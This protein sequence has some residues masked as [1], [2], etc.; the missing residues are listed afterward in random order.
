MAALTRKGA[1]VGAS[2]SGGRRAPRMA[3]MRRVLSLGAGVQSSVVLLMSARGELPSLDL[4]IFADTGWEPRAVYQHLDWLEAEAAEAPYPV[5]IERTSLRGQ[6]LRDD[7]I[8]NRNA[9]GVDGFP[10]IPLYTTDP[11]NGR[12][13]MVRRQCTQDYKIEPIKRAI[14]AAFAADITPGVPSV[15]QWFG[16]SWDESQRMRDSDVRYIVNAYP[17]IDLRMTRAGCLDWFA[18]R[19]PSRTLPRSACLGCPMKSDADWLAL[20]DADP[21]EYADTLAIDDAMREREDAR[22]WRF[23]LHRRGPLREVVPALA[24]AKQQQPDM[25]ADMFA[26]DCS[27]HCGV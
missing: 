6:S 15:E 17:L 20:A 4:A 10:A 18:A 2:L 12:T 13:S 7:V 5:R 3:R 25:F 24:L 26:E 11:A 9:R 27:G 21:L 14:R 16:I 1:A 8:A 22:G 19:Y 23:G